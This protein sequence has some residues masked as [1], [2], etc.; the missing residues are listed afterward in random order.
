MNKLEWLNW[1]TEQ[2]LIEK[3][4][5]YRDDSGP[6]IQWANKQWMAAVYNPEHLEVTEDYSKVVPEELVLY[7]FLEFIVREEIDKRGWF[8]SQFDTKVYSDKEC[9]QYEGREH[10][11]I[12]SKLTPVEE[13][14]FLGK[15]ESKDSRLE[16][17]LEAFKE[18][19]SG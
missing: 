2:G 3:D 17:L 11:V 4:I 10:R 1:A 8:L 13:N 9:T 15:G 6:W 12:I 14:G 16:A 5:D 18:A 7:E 19:V